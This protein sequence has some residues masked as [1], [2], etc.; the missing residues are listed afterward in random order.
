MMPLASSGGK[1]RRTLPGLKREK[2]K[3]ASDM[4]REGTERVNLPV[5]LKDRVP[6]SDQLSNNTE[7]IEVGTVRK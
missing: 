5:T 4:S 6:Y 2:K 1:D 7:N 3:K